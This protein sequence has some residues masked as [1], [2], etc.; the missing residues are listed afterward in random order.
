MLA[1][2][3]MKWTS[4]LG[5]KI[6]LDSLSMS[7]PDFH[8]IHSYPEAS[9]EELSK[10]FGITVERVRLVRRGTIYK[11]GEITEDSHLFDLVY[12]SMMYNPYPEL[13]NL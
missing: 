12:E 7:R 6:N 5:Y 9:T 2:G 3:T 11:R 10:K 13:R 1:L 4:C 8:P